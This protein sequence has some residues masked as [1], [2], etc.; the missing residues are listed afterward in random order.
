MPIRSSTVNRLRLLLF[1]STA[2]TTSSNSPDARP[3]MSR[4]PL[5]T[6]SKEPGQT[7]RLMGRDATPPVSPR[8]DRDVL[9]RRDVLHDPHV[10]DGVAVAP[11]AQGDQRRRPREGG[12][13][14]ALD[15]DD[16]VGRQPAVRRGVREPARDLRVRDGVRRI[17]QHDVVGPVRGPAQHRGGGRGPD[18]GPGQ[19]EVGDVA[20]QHPGGPPV[21]LDEQR[22]T[23]PP[24]RAPPARAPRTRRTGRARRRRPGPDRR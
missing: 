8:V 10:Q 1:T 18:R 9:M 11:L 21:R 19:T 2:T 7:A 13:P 14:A 23:R 17:D 3:T 24:A 22:V 6:G 12:A 20:P 15:D 4:C 16:R 5:V